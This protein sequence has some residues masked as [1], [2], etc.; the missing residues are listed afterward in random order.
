MVHGAFVDSSSWAGVYDILTE[1]GFNVSVVQIPTISLGDVAAT[2]LILD[3]QD[4]PTFLVGHSYGGVVITEAGMHP[5]GAALVYIAAFASDKGES[6][7]SIV[8]RPRSLTSPKGGY[9]F[10]DKEK[11]AAAFG[12][13][14][15]PRTAAFRAHSQAP[16]GLEAN[17]AEITKPSWREKPSWYAA[18]S[19]SNT[20]LIKPRRLMVEA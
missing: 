16:F 8:G 2:N 15:D 3:E 14:V 9:L 4:G 12:A 5:R 18:P 6:V 20:S 11:M 7:L 1:D 10:Q 19:A 13:D 17:D